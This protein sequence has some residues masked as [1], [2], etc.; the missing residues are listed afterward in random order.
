MFSRPFSK[1]YH[2][3]MEL[4]FDTFKQWHS[5]IVLFAQIIENDL[6]W[7]YAFM[8]G[9]DPQ[10]NYDELI[11]MKITFGQVVFELRQ[12]DHDRFLD[13]EDYRFLQ[14]MAQ[15]RNYWCH[16]CALDFVY[17]PNFLHS[18]AYAQACHR[19]FVDHERF[20]DVNENVERARLRAITVYGKK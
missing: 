5:D 16:R 11:Q 1:V 12:L 17:E 15:K 2:E 20:T 19:L 14:G 4:K 9:G 3:A 18:E 7:I 8:R 13:E 6:K 10:K